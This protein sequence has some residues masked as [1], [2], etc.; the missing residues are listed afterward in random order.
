MSPDFFN[1][2]NI[3]IQSGVGEKV[4]SLFILSE[5]TYPS[6]FYVDMLLGFNYFQNI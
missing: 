2:Q 1:M 3:W 5:L 4:K 6:S